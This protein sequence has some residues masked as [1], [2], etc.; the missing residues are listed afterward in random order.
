MGDE[1]PKTVTRMKES[2]VVR[3]HLI[4]APS[5][6]FNDRCSGDFKIC[7]I[8]NSPDFYTDFGEIIDNVYL[9]CLLR[10]LVLN[11]IEMFCY[12][13]QILSQDRRD[14]YVCICAVSSSIRGVKLFG[15]VCARKI[16]NL[17][18]QYTVFLPRRII[19]HNYSKSYTIQV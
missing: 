4:R 7:R 16:F 6:A 1:L 18:C 8:W 15:E 14:R 5:N 12:L 13:I 3:I 10:V 2:T 9:S 19:A 17:A 11:E